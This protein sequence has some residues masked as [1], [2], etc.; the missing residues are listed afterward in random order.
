MPTADIYSPEPNMLERRFADYLA[1]HGAESGG[2]A[3]PSRARLA[4][5]GRV[6]RW[7]IGLSALAGLVSGGLIGVTEIWMRQTYLGG[8]DGFDWEDA[9]PYWSA[10]YAFVGVVSAVEIALLYALALNGIARVTQQSGLNLSRGDGPELFSHSLAR[11]ALEF[12]SPKVE[13]Y[14]IDPYVHVSAWKLVALNIAYKLKVG[15][16]SFIL[17]VFLRRVAARMAI[18]GMVPLFAGP[19]YAVWNA[20]IIWRIMAEARVRTLGPFAVDGLM[21]AHFDDVSGLDAT[22]RD[23]ILQAAGEMLTRGRDAH[24]NQIYLMT[25]LRKALERD[26]DIS[27]DWSAV[28][29]HLPALDAASQTRVLDLL[30]LS[31]V[32]GARTHREQTEFLS[33]AC[34]ACGATL[35]EKRLKALRKA[36]TR[37]DQITRAALSDTRSDGIAHTA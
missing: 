29:D 17:R 28:R 27:L 12:P 23:V 22:E 2:S 24:P 18:R 1:Q 7:V 37:G 8:M 35:D 32:I 16:S 33:N 9:L 13:I 20:Y 3:H 11:A 5:I 30:T 6:T 36:L 34:D 31:C 4:E 15:V 26:E 19:L 14:G 25:R 10:F 21:D